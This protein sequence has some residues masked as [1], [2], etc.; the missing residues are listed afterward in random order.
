ML[1]SVTGS[2][3]FNASYNEELKFAKNW[4]Q[5]S[6][7]IRNKRCHLTQ[8]PRACSFEHQP[9]SLTS[10]VGFCIIFRHRLPPNCHGIEPNKCHDQRTVLF[11][12]M[13]G[14]IILT[15]RESKCVHPKKTMNMSPAPISYRMSDCQD[16]DFSGNRVKS[17][18]S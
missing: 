13:S 16:H 8:Q 11:R 12:F 10:N 7:L 5:Y 6:W 2:F 1:F 4:L 9:C 15:P 17:M 14:M 3:C 18:P